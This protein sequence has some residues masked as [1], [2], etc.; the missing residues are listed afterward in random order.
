M[1]PII[2]TYTNAALGAKLVISTA[3][4]NNGDISGTFSIGSQSWKINGT[5]NTSTITPNAVFTFS[6]S[7]VNPT[8][9][10]G[11]AG[12][13][14][15]YQTFADT[16]ISVSMAQTGGVVNSVSGVFVRS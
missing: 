9:M 12:A 11:G 3:N 16:T 4:D 10:V 2:G 1:S 13:S 8:V 15:N 5:W 14:A 7:G 6:G